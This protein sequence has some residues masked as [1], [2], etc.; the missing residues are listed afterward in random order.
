MAAV[1][2]HQSVLVDAEVFELSRMFLQVVHHSQLTQRATAHQKWNFSLNNR[3]SKKKHPVADLN[4]NR[5]GE[6]GVEQ[7]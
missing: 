6:A 3:S 2:R 5:G 4:H 1:G 7:S